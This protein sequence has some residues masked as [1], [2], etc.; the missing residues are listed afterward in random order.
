MP[1]EFI[2]S[3]L[4]VL[5]SD[6][7]GV[8]E[9]SAPVIFLTFFLATFVSED[10]ACLA[11]GVL[12]GQ[13]RISLAL[14]VSACVLG[15]FV[16]DM[17]LYWIGRIFGSR[18]VQ[19]RFFRRYVS[20]ESISQATAWLEKRGASAVFL[21]RFLPGV[22]LPTYLAAGFLRA[23]FGKFALYFLIAS[24]IW[25]PIL[26]GSAAYASL[27]LIPGGLIVEIVLMF[28]AVRFFFYITSWRSRRLLV[29]R[30]K[31]TL[32]WEFWPIRIFYLPIVL[33]VLSLGMK[34]RSLTLFT[35]VNPGIPSGGFV[36]ESK[37]D[38]Y[39]RLG[40][41]PGTNPFLLK[42]VLLPSDVSFEEN[43]GRAK[44]FISE[45]SL[46]Y[47]VVLKPDAGERGRGVKIVRDKSELVA[48]LKENSRDTILQEYFD[49]VEA[50]VFY[51]RHPDQDQGSIFSITEKHFPALIGD[52]R[53][54]L[55]SLILKDRR[56][57]C[58]AK[59]YFV[60]NRDRLKSIP[61]SGEEVKIIDIGTH[62]MGAI[63]LDGGWLETEALLNQIDRIARGFEGF[64]FGRFDIRAR[65]FA[66]L[67]A[68]DNFRVIELN[69]VTSES[70]NIYDP[71]YSL[72]DAYRV[73]FRQWE[74]AFE[75]G[76]KNRDLGASPTR[77]KDMINLILRR[78][79]NEKTGTGQDELRAID[80]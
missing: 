41:G 13:G 28:I 51:F 76:A 12:A 78:S 38:I 1:S 47:P 11:A 36:G 54:D 44:G 33:Y 61:G 58:L 71:R 21:S 53:A 14:A 5:N 68:G 6:L 74:I 72:F 10:G 59:S 39:Y 40:R 23:N 80:L 50:S 43:F 66:D 56:A 29:G 46:S 4:Q 79:T 65:S 25:T 17:L 77:I 7:T 49:G 42:H 73:L 34:H 69:G 60:Q 31:R 48:N 45:W 24:I 70:T 15:I 9:F 67:Q 3:V 26:V 35:C 18:V 75:I 16:G 20:N 63:F 52:G 19:T 22:R 8:T 27:S 37:D 62:S 32:N 57:V 64:Y 30:I 55:E 2:Q